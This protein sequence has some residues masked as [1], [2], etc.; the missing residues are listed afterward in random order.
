MI[1]LLWSCVFANEKATEW[2]PSLVLTSKN[3]GKIPA[4]LGAAYDALDWVPVDQAA[5]VLVELALSESGSE[6]GVECFNLVN[7]RLGHWRDMVQAIQAFHGRDNMYVEAV[8]FGQWLAELEAIEVTDDTVVRYPAI[9][10]ID[11][12]KKMS[13]SSSVS[14]LN[15]APR[16]AEERSNVLRGLQAVDGRLMHQWLEGGVL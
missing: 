11:F 3:L 4:S 15:F 16:K 7:P 2:L 14:R 6:R 1:R 12:F 13:A 5:Q 10:L 8:E 9:K